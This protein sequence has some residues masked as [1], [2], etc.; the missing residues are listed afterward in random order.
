MSLIEQAA[1]RLEQLR[2]AG[3]DV[4]ASSADE[5]GPLAV[6]EQHHGVDRP[7]DAETPE[8]PSPSRPGRWSRKRR[9]RGG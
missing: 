4:P 6:A 1:Q 7:G 3:V 8:P 9:N 2:K 5:A